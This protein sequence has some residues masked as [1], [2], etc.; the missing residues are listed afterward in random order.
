MRTQQ[1]PRYAY[2]RDHDGCD[3]TFDIWDT[4]TGHVI[5]SVH[6]WDS[7]EDEEFEA[8]EAARLIVWELNLNGPRNVRA[9]DDVA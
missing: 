4:Q 1:A 5:D 3:D 2:N 9:F 6:F 8:E 7:I